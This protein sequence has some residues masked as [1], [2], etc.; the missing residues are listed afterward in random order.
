MNDCVFAA[1]AAG[2]DT[3]LGWWTLAATIVAMLAL[4]GGRPVLPG[5]TS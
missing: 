5:R 1:V 3:A 2:G 4:G